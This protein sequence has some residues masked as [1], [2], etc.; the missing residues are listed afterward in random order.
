LRKNSFEALFFIKRRVCFV[1]AFPAIHP[2][3]HPRGAADFVLRS[4]SA[5]DIDRTLS[6]EIPESSK[7]TLK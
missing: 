1:F 3:Y 6:T 7:R 5:G 4:L 2:T